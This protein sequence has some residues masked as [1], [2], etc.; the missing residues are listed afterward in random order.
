M[1][2]ESWFNRLGSHVSNTFKTAVKMA[3][4]AKNGKSEK[5]KA[6][7]MG[8]LG[9]EVANLMSKL[10]QL[11]QSLSDREI[12]RLR[13]DVI[14]LPGVRKVVS[15]DERFLL[16]L[17]CAEKLENLTLLAGAVAR[18]GRKCKDPALQGFEHVFDDLL[19]NNIDFK[20]LMFSVKEMDVKIKKLEKYISTTTNL[21]QELE[22]LA[23]LEQSLKR[24][25]SGEEG[26]RI[27]DNSL[28][29]IQ[30][31]LSWQ[32]QETKYLRE[33]SLWNRTYDAVVGLLAR[34][35]F[36]T[37]GRIRFSFGDLCFP[38]P[39]NNFN[40]NFPVAS[41]DTSF[42]R[43]LSVSA[44]GMAYASEK[45]EIRFSS[46]PLERG[47]VD[48]NPGR[49]LGPVD[50]NPGRRLGP[51]LN[52]TGSNKVWQDRERHSFV[53]SLQSFVAEN[54]NRLMTWGSGS[55]ARHSKESNPSLIDGNHPWAKQQDSSNGESPIVFSS[56]RKVA[57]NLSSFNVSMNGY[58]KESDAGGHLANGFHPVSTSD[59]SNQNNTLKLFIGAKSRLLNAPASTLG[60]AALALHYANVIIV[61]E[62]LV[63]FPHLIGPDARDDL[64]QM[65]PTSLRMAL[66]SRLRSCTKNITPTMYNAALAADWSDALDRILD[67]LAPLA[68]NMIRWQ[69]ERNFEQQ[70][71]VPRTNVLLLQTLYFANQ[72][73]TELAITE[74]LVGLNY[75]CRY[76]QE[77]RANALMEC[78]NHD[79]DEYLEWQI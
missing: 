50:M 63:R 77:I 41:L 45:R 67:W 74:L 64:Y 11:W 7:V 13:T 24:L 52:R 70:H 14:T 42:P 8:V 53:G 60:G 55:P 58:H 9:F 35:V 46:G 37:Y 5:S 15:N 59:S 47:P 21:Y 22:V 78:S 29:S 16:G 68:H 33:I 71:L 75:I 12:A 27:K 76:E 34:V 36:T 4:G 40:F 69:S 19:C 31:K 79:Y 18:L 66:R 54:S 25:Q 38:G 10:V 39:S 2:L 1:V 49:R 57:P 20:V 51:V 17:A 65:L 62:K 44:S 30:Q 6:G 48:M 23:D 56:S 28:H 73:K 3:A 32:R 26:S 43:S 61:I 72:V